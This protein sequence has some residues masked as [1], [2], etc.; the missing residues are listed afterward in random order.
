MNVN[1]WDFLG[2][3]PSDRVSVVM[4]IQKCF[5]GFFF[6]RDNN[7][8]EKLCSFVR[9]VPSVLFKSLFYLLFSTIRSFLVLRRWG[10][11]AQS[12][13]MWDLFFLMPNDRK[14]EFASFCCILFSGPP[15]SFLPSVSPFWQPDIVC[16]DMREDC[17][18]ACA[19]GA[20]EAGDEHHGEDHRAAAA[21]G[22]NGESQRTC[23]RT[24]INW[25]LQ[26][27]WS[28]LPVPTVLAVLQ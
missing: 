16:Q 25:E 2:G 22:P 14:A 20:V 6:L 21:H 8:V 18:E 24:N 13:L 7:S 28:W 3:F 17:A 12:C 1:Q 27:V 9:G 26:Y 15:F 19:E 4:R 23:N 5:T 10:C 11:S